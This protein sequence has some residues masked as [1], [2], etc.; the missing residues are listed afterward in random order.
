MT[1]KKTET[2]DFKF[3]LESMDEGTGTFTGY[4]S[5]FGVV[6]SYGDTVMAG[7]F[8]RTIKNNKGKGWPMLW[9][10]KVD[11]PIGLITGEEDERGLKVKG[12]FNLEDPLA[13]RIRSHMKQGSVTGL[14]IGY[15]TMV[16]EMDK[17]SNTRKLK[18]IKLWEISP[19]VFPACDPARV[20]DVKGLDTEGEPTEKRNDGKAQLGGDPGKPTPQS[21]TDKLH[22]FIVLETARVL[23][24]RNTWQ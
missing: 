24:H 1:M 15:Q 18:E 19:V 4:A 21:D 12:A 20:E 11:E 23:K 16:E 5:V 10:H 13:L 8:K 3:T 22:S 2:K 6:D 17:E 9:S 7:A 14:S